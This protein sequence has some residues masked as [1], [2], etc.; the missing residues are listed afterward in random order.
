MLPA[1]AVCHCGVVHVC[2]LPYTFE[3]RGHLYFRVDPIHFFFMVV[4]DVRT[5]IIAFYMVK[6][7]SLLHILPI[8]HV[9]HVLHP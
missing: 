1:F 4:D 6:K 3:G 7:H 9:F 5:K 8:L 2:V